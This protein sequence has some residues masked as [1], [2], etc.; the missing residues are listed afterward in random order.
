MLCALCLT[1]SDIRVVSI[2]SFVN[3]LT[4]V[5]KLC[6]VSVVTIDGVV[7]LFSWVVVFVAFTFAVCSAAGQILGARVQSVF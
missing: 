2:S 7:S 5:S 3:S 4:T 6:A 1:T